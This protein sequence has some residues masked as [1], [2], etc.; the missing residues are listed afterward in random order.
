MNYKN[1][2]G[3]IDAYGVENFFYQS[4]EK[5]IMDRKRF[6]EKK[7]FVE[8]PKRSAKTIAPSESLKPKKIYYLTHCFFPES[9]GGTERFIYNI[10][11]QQMGHSCQVKIFTYSTQ[12]KKNYTKSL[13]NILYEQYFFQGIEVIKFR[14]KKAPKGILKD[15]ILDDQ[16]VI[17]F[18]N[19]FLTKER[20]D[21]VH[22]GHLGRVASFLFAC[23]KMGVPYIVTITDFYAICHYYTMI[24]KNGDLCD[25]CE[26]GLKCREKCSTKM[27]RSFEQ[28]YLSAKEILTNASAVTAPSAYVATIIEKEF[29]DIIVYTVPHGINDNIFTSRKRSEV[30][31]FLYLGKLSALKGVYLLIKAFKKLEEADVTL[32]IYGT[33]NLI[34]RVVLK[35][36]TSGD[37]RIVLHGDV[38]FDQIASV[39][40]KADCVII[41]SLWG[42]TYNFVLSEAHAA[43]VMV[44]ASRIGA[45]PERIEEGVNGYL[46]ECGDEKSL[47][48]ALKRAISNPC[49]DF[50]KKSV[51]VKQEAAIYHN[52]YETA[53][54]SI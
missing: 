48:Q 25:G 46:F 42:E 40:E 32:D 13:G 53:V 34:Y 1:I 51:G 38:A 45:L 28:R 2:L 44:I 7:T 36:E 15:I 47:I 52:L 19:F 3:L 26:R 16:D 23:Q 39:Y 37:K 31:R 9:Q 29:P 18:A 21:V 12:T 24:D 35:K 41:P 11:K 10:A 54:K 6:A 17:D 50:P 30:R 43:G 14:H 5:T 8:F 49:F 27:V 4:I 22:C 33:G 20:P